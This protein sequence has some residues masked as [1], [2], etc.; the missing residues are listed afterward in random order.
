MIAGTV[1][2]AREARIPLTLRSPLG[3]SQETDA[4][5]DTGF[6]GFLTL[7]PSLIAGLGLKRLARGRAILADGREQLFDIHAVV[8]LWDGQP[9]TVEAD[10]ADTDPLV[11]MGLLQGYELSMEV[12]DGG[13]VS[14][15]RAS[16]RK[17]WRNAAIQR[18]STLF[19]SAPAR[20]ATPMK[21]RTSIC[22]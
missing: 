21:S 13:S 3:T 11:G 16:S 5:I 7:P 2:A 4:L 17:A 20:A 19:C 15:W 18:S 14:S 10:S 1:T 6:N 8:V 9:L 22:S 12:V